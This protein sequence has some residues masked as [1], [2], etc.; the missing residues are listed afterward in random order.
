MLLYVILGV[1]GLFLF[2]RSRQVPTAAAVGGAAAGA[3]AGTTAG[4]TM[5]PQITGPPVYLQQPSD[6][7]AQQLGAA[8]ALITSIGG[9]AGN[10]GISW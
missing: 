10:L 4:A 1:L 2:W 6:S 8:A 5:T 9:L 7:T 3:A